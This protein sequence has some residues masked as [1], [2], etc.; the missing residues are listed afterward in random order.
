MSEI[1][2]E[3][4][5]QIK[6]VKYFTELSKILDDETLIAKINDKISEC[7]GLINPKTAMFILARENNFCNDEENNSVPVVESL[8]IFDI[9]DFARNNT[10][11]DYKR[12]NL[13]DVVVLTKDFKSGTTNGKKW[14]LTTLEVS[15]LVSDPFGNLYVIKIRVFGNEFKDIEHSSKITLK[16]MFLE[17]KQ[18]EKDGKIIKY[19]SLSFD[20]KSE[21]IIL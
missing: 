21:L 14:A 13:E 16:N 17:I 6:D 2:V 5:L 18:F 8:D 1:I 19:A 12:I 20:K 7:K 3:N 10:V 11:G 9:K 15:D 4:I